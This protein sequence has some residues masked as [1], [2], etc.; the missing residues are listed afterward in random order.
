MKMNK[1][2]LNAMLGA[3]IVAFTGCNDFLDKSPDSRIEL[4]TPE[5]IT[6]LLVSG[7]SDQNYAALN[8]L[9][10][11]NFIDNN[12]PDENGVYYNL[13]SFERMHDEIFAWQDAVSSTDTDSPSA[14]WSGSYYAI[15]VANEALQAIEKFEEQGR[16]SEVS[17]QKGEALLIRA[18][19]HFILVNEFSQAYRND[20][21]SKNDSGVPYITKPETKVLVKYSRSTVTETYNKIEKDL[22]A[23]INLIRDGGYS[24]PKYHF[25][26]QA[27]NA[28]AARFYLFKREY[29]KVVEYASKVLGNNAA[30]YM[31]DWNADYPTYS[32]FAY[33]WISATSANNFLLMPTNSTFNRIFG[34][35]YGC[36]REASK[37]T[38]YGKGP[39]WQSYNFAPCYSG[40]LYIRGS[41][42]YGLFFPKIGE[43]F[44]Y[45]DKIAGIGFPHIV[46]AEFTGEET[47]LC[48]AEAYVYLNRI[49][50]AVADLKTFDDSRKISDT[51]YPDLTE[52]LIRSF[53]KSTN[54]LFV[55][56]FNTTSMSPDFIV[57]D[58][59]KPIL[60]CVLHFRRL[61]T[62]FDGLRWFDLKRYGIEI[63]HKIGKNTDILK[64]ND[65]RRALQIPAEVIAAGISPNNRKVSTDDAEIVKASAPLQIKN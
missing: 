31:R 30:D 33:G 49:A 36:N 46:R 64:W 55:S 1:Y 28:F 23:G 41:Q 8:E 60:D 52:A 65:P 58:S 24:I 17:A 13:S 3:T 29:E 40:R 56:T 54:T 63:T 37:A 59:Q 27:A 9:S 12:S 22:L 7:Y 61:E 26:S 50:D 43:F 25:N 21:L 34:T 44:E 11:D 45:T 16:A 48:R 14:V 4:D 57:T 6:K 18:Y 32:E 42:D 62:I 20:E 2:I 15:A 53:Y 47:L 35:R 39:T 51:N 5:K 38:I 19:H 10:A